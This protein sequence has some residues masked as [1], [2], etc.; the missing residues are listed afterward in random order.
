M[1]F[2][3]LAEYL[4]K[5]NTLEKRSDGALQTY[6]TADDRAWTSNKLERSILLHDII[7]RPSS[8]KNHQNGDIDISGVSKNECIKKMAELRKELDKMH[9]LYKEASEKIESLEGVAKESRKSQNLLRDSEAKIKEQADMIA[10][11]KNGNSEEYE[12][13]LKERDALSEKLKHVKCLESLMKKMKARADEADCMEEEIA[14]LKRELEKC[15]KPSECGDKL[16]D[17]SELS[18]MK[19]QSYCEELE[20]LKQRIELEEKRSTESMAERNFLRQKTRTIDLIEAELI[21]Y[22]NNYDECEC[23]IRALKE[24]ICKN[25]SAVRLNQQ[26]MCQLKD[27]ESRLMDA[28]CENDCL[29]VSFKK[30]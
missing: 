2:S 3:S 21:L 16:K 13:L 22:K 12:K 5:F 9:D 27:A 29:I 23:K 17:D 24:V 1:A 25:E 19:C 10:D 6:A 7:T 30:L 14:N 4:K 8:Q 20:K 15:N 26:S 11:L 28:E 18:C